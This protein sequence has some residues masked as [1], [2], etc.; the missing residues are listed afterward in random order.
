MQLEVLHGDGS[1]VAF[2]ALVKENRK[3][4]VLHVKENGDLLNQ[5][6]NEECSLADW[7]LVDSAKGGSGKGF[8]WPSLLY[9]QLEAYMGGPW[10][11]GSTLGMFVKCF[12]P[13]N[14]ME[15]TLVVAFVPPRVFRRISTNI[16]FHERSTF[17][18]LLIKYERRE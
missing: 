11:E 9:H 14:L 8:N 2:P 16:F 17:C 7:V 15:L 1:R 6:S 18:T 3:I 12:P 4:Y 5:I 10:K 13:S